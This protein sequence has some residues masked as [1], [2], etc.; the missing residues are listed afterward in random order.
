MGLGPGTVMSSKP[1]TAWVARPGNSLWKPQ[2]WERHL[3]SSSPGEAKL[4]LL[5]LEELY[6]P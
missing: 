5:A 1:F 4:G 3:G 2:L 6:F